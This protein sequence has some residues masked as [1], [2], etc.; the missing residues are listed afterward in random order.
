MAGQA[1]QPTWASRAVVALAGLLAVVLLTAVGVAALRSSS[2]ADADTVLEEGVGVRLELADGT[3][4]EGV[5]GERVPRGA[6]VRAGTAGAVLQTRE[7]RVFLGQATALTVLDGAR[8][9]LD[10]GYVMVEASDGPGLE[11]T[12]TAAVV[13][14]AD[15]SLVRVVA[16]PLVR[17]GVLRGDAA[18]VRAAGR[19]ATTEVPRFYQAQVAPGGLPT[20]ATPLLLTGDAFEMRL[21]RELYD[22]DRDLNALARRLDTVGEAGPA[23]LAV[24]SSVV[25]TAAPVP[26]APGSE[27]AL[28]FLLAA[29]SDPDQA[30]EAYTEVRGL[31]TA[32]GSW[33]VVA[34]LVG[35]TPNEVSAVLGALLAPDAV[36]VLASGPVGPGSSSAAD[37][38]PLLLDPTGPGAPTEA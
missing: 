16:G 18:R 37:L 25:P 29:A 24:L 20:E 14:A 27:R 15:G 13:T 19:Q 9:S 21:A 2:V 30:G 12:T 4:R 17:V 7:R 33:G 22:A 8:Q 10:A 6:T 26:G 36:P 31:R 28:G 1:G 5:V 3:A 11:L 35:T 38:L 32:G 23:V 34:A